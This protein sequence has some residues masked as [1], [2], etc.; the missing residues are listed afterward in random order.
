MDTPGATKSTDPQRAVVVLSGGQDSTTALYWALHSGF[1]IVQAVTFDYGQRHAVELYAA[2][3]VAD[4]AQ[5]P[6]EVIHVGPVLHGRSPLV[7]FSENL[8]TYED[9]SQMSAVI[10]T[11]LELTFVPMRNVLFFALAANRAACLDCRVLISGV[12]RDDAANYPD[13]RREFVD[14]MEVTVTRALGLRQ[15]FLIVT[16]LIG[17]SKVDSV[18]MAQCLP[19]C[20]DA[21]AWTH[22]SYT[23]GY[24]PTAKDHASVL[25][26]HGFEEAGVPDPLVVRAW[27]EGLMELPES[28][29]Y[30]ELRKAS[31]T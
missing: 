22:T 8:E 14:A 5:V 27:K 11:R 3:K 7:N 17:V 12:C 24:P 28:R 30:D 25:R 21:L 10:G 26:A 31:G 23:G 20:W 19:G 6:H 29:N 15:Q 1:K 18:K 4:M 13:C 2:R 9:F 16:P